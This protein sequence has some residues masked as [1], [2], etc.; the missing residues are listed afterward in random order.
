MLDRIKKLQDVG[1]VKRS[2]SDNTKWI[3][4]TKEWQDIVRVV[5]LRDMGICQRCG[6]MITGKSIVDHIEEITDDNVNDMNKV[7]G[8]DNLQLLCIECH[9]TKTAKY[10]RGVEEIVQ[11]GELHVDRRHEIND[12]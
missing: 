8:L 9:N 3:Y 6:Y 10:Q 5:R 12:V 1:K 2:G 4:K 11:R 7:F